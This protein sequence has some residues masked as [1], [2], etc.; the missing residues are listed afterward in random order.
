M[1]AS[2][3]NL[4]LADQSGMTALHWAAFNDDTDVIEFLLSKDAKIKISA[5]DFS[6]K[7]RATKLSPVDIA[8]LCNN[9]KTVRVFM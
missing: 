4:N 5:K 1:V 6:T 2:G 7:T 3:C 9:E 8:G